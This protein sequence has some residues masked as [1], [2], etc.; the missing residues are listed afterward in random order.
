MKITDV[1]SL[2]DGK[3]YMI[4]SKTRYND[5][6][7]L[8]LVDVNNYDNVRFGYLEDD[9]IIFIKRE[10]ISEVLVLKLLKQMSKLIINKE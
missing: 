8:C 6:V 7:Y 4:T 1:L 3:N 10:S 9:N 2:S 5:K